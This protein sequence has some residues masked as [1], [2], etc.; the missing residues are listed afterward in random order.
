[1]GCAKSHDMAF[2]REIKQKIKNRKSKNGFSDSKNGFSDFYFESIPGMKSEKSA[3]F[4]ALKPLKTRN[5]YI[6]TSNRIPSLADFSMQIQLKINIGI[7]Q[8][9]F[10]DKKSIFYFLVLHYFPHLKVIFFDFFEA[11]K[12]YKNANFAWKIH[13]LCLQNAR[14]RF[15]T[16]FSS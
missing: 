8:N 7:F 1:M 5:F 13:I 6:K 4:K 11:W 10:F 12:S 2:L 15:E 16:H 14:K 9:R 3:F